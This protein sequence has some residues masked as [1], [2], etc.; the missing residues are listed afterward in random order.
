MLDL[1]LALSILFVALSLA[2][3]AVLMLFRDVTLRRR[4]AVDQG[5][6]NGGVISTLPRLQ[7]PM[8]GPPPRSLTGRIDYSFDRLVVESGLALTSETAFLVQVFCG[9]LLGGMLFI[10]HDHELA[11]VG[12]MLVGMVASHCYFQFHRYRRQHALREQLPDAMDM[13]ARAVR[14]GETLDQA[15]ALAGSTSPNPLGLE[16]RRCARQMDMGLSME[17]TM[18]SL[19]RRA[20]LT[21]VRILAAAFMVQ[22]QTGG[23][24][25]LTLERLAAVIRDR[26]SHYRH[27]RAST[28]AGRIGTMLIVAAGPLVALYMYVW[29]RDYIM[30]FVELPHGWQLLGAAAGLQLIG[31]LWVFR[32]L[33]TDY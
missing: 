13:M 12:G 17:A 22:R 30:K 25:P 2:T 28:A 7:L 27:F 29:Q 32:L 6:A 20:A 24:L 21:E 31:L 9:L 26:L 3:A 19:V 4:A 16:I 18:R 23:N 1:N 5:L 33:R 14:A 8:E 15:M 10:W 11:G